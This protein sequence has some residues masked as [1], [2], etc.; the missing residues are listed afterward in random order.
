MIY[1]IGD[2]IIV[3]VNGTYRV[4]VVTQ[5]RK[6][7]RGWVYSANLENGKILTEC[8]VSKDLTDYHIHRG[9]SKQLNNGN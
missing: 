2:T 4:G 1:S 9:L 6:V 3:N 7:K 8:S 5:K